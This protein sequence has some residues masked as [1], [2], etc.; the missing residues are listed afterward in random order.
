MRALLDAG[1]ATRR[2]LIDI[3]CQE[4]RRFIADGSVSRATVAA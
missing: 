1:A 3:V 2:D 4:R